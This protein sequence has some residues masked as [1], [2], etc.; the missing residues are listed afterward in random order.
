MEIILVQINSHRS[1]PN[2][3]TKEQRRLLQSQTIYIS[4]LLQ[5][6]LYPNWTGASPNWQSSTQSTNK[7]EKEVACF[8]FTNTWTYTLYKLFGS[9]FTT[10]YILWS[11]NP[12]KCC[13][14]SF[15]RDLQATW[16]ISSLIC[17]EESK[18][19]YLICGIWD[20]HAVFVLLGSWW[21]LWST[22]YAALP[23]THFYS[24]YHAFPLPKEGNQQIPSHYLMTPH[25][26]LSFHT[27]LLSPDLVSDQN[28]WWS[29]TTVSVYLIR[30]SGLSF[31]TCTPLVKSIF[32]GLCTILVLDSFLL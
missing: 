20:A 2:Q 9:I 23:S 7:R 17:L 4:L 27:W 24:F 26:V 11:E 32:D 3:P 6:G 22:I 16:P 25:I 10:K 13:V 15:L 8:Y 29:S 5:L 31:L 1:L 21:S 14:C 18:E 19:H 30:D 12:P 28:H